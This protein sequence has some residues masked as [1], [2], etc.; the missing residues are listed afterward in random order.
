MSRR[1]NVPR[2]GTAGNES[3]SNS[4]GLRVRHA[5]GTLGSLL[6]G[7]PW[8]T[9]FDVAACPETVDFG[10]SAGESEARSSRP[11]SGSNTSAPGAKPK[12]ASAAD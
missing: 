12:T 8:S 3:F 9:L 1:G 11:P 7:Q 4:N 6:A 2:V 10:G 5:H